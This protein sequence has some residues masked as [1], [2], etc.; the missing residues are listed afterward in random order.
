MNHKNVLTSNSNEWYTPQYLFDY[1]DAIY[2][3]TLD[4]CATELSAKCDKYYTIED[5]GLSQSWDNEVVFCNPPYGRDIK[6]WIKKGSEIKNGIC[7]ML[8]PARTDT[9]Y[10][11]EHIFGKASDI[12]FIKGRISFYR[13]ENGKLVEGQSSTFPSAIVVFGNGNETK[14]GYVDIKK[15]NHI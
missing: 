14:Y 6:H 12:L 13:N 8:I 1:L 2:K 15:E 11:H 3:F 7:V 4:P 10:W 5:D 9:K